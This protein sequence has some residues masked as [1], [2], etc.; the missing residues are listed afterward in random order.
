M[1]IFVKNLLNLNQRFAKLKLGFSC[2]GPVQS[3]IWQIK[4]TRPGVISFKQRPQPQMILILIL[5]FLCLITDL[6]NSNWDLPNFNQI[7]AKFWSKICLRRSS[8]SANFNQR[9]A[10][11]GPRV[12]FQQR[13]QPQL[14]FTSTASC[15]C[16]KY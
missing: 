2:T 9:F 13:P 10:C 12:V 16:M 7:F 11:T 5:H 14:A 3:K 15:C 6:P 8:I 4:I 1:H